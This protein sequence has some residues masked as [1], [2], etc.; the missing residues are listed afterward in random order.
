M[1]DS[2]TDKY[3]SSVPRPTSSALTR[4]SGFLIGY[5]HSLNP[6]TGCRFACSYC[7]VRGMPLH[8]YHEPA[9]PWG[10]YAH[11]RTGIA[12]QL[13][14]ELKRFEK[15]GA[16]DGVAVLM[17]SATDPYQP[18]ERRWRLTRACLEAFVR[19]PPALINVQTR[20]PL[21]QDDFTLLREL[22]ERCWLNVSLETDLEDVRRVVTPRCPPLAARIEALR[23]ARGAGLNVQVTVS[24]C[25]PFSSVETFGHLLIELGHRVIVD[26]YVAGDGQRGRRTAATHVPDIYREHGWPDWRSEAQ[27]RALY[28]WLRERMG[29]RVGWSQQGFAALPT[30]LIAQ[31]KQ[32]S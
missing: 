29:D 15:K 18:L 13:E 23:S 3:L 10:E 30:M 20:S 22:G 4:A 14:N 9:I 21:V 26:S 7:Y 17:S 1:N 12:E 2:G 25:L 28:E 6:Y 19:H 31:R 8:R 11:P 32:P 16:L 5:T 24:P 27:P